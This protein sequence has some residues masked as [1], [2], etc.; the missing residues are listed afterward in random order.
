M[1]R[2]S[3]S[4][5]AAAMMTAASAAT[6][7]FWPSPLAAKST[8]RTAAAPTTPVS[9]VRA[10]VDSATAVRDAEALT[11]NPWTSPAAILAAP[12]AVISWFMSTC[13]SRR[14]ASVLDN[15]AVSASI[16]KAM[17]AAARNSDVMSSNPTSGMLGD[18]KPDG[19]AC[20]RRGGHAP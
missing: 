20:R 1:L 18:G 16:T 10:P 3:S 14:A 6:G 2:T 7:R 8:T 4:V 12:T 11:G 15:V 5:H 13:S 9:C 19:I 17:P